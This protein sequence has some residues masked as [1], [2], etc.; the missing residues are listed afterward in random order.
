ME[1]GIASS[2]PMNPGSTQQYIHWI[3]GSPCLRVGGRGVKLT[4]FLHNL[5]LVLRL[6][7]HRAINLLPLTSLR[8]IRNT[9]KTCIR[10]TTIRT[11]TLHIRTEDLRNTKE[12]SRSF[13]RDPRRQSGFIYYGRLRQQ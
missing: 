10:G 12:E 2:C 5:H 3:S 11:A 13:D 4:I 6:R 1:S 8:L 7:T 9:G